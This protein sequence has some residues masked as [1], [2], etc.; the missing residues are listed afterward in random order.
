MKNTLLR[1]PAMWAKYQAKEPQ[2]GCF[3]CDAEPLEEFDHWKIIWNDYPYDAVAT[4]H[5][6]LV[7]LKHV[8]TRAT[9]PPQASKELEAI[10]DTLEQ[11]K[12]Y[13]CILE[14]FSRARSQQT[15][16]HLHLIQWKRAR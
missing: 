7:P 10:L 12:R 16:Y 6:M 13:D 11:T 5:Y 15:H 1:T 8:A 9:V 3:I 4:R 14:N 2:D